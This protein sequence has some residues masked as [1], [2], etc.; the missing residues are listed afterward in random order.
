[1]KKLLFIFLL[2]VTTSAA[3][4]SGLELQLRNFPIAAYL[5]KPIDTL[6]ANLPA[7]YDTAFKISSAGCLNSGASLQINYPKYQFWIV[8]EI[9]VIYTL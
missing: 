5:N 8:V 1:M 2:F 4:Q 9:T 7:G 3:A 6:I